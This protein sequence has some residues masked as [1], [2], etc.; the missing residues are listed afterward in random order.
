MKLT[1]ILFKL[2]VF[3]VSLV[4]DLNIFAVDLLNRLKACHISQV[5][6]KKQV[7]EK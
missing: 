4:I 7:C 5:Y 1:S 3:K 6:L 2:F